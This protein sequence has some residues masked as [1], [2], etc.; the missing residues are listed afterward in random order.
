MKNLSDGS[1]NWDIIEFGGSGIEEVV[2][3]FILGKI[4]KDGTIVEFGAG[5][6]STKV[7]SQYFTLYSVEH[8]PEFVGIYDEVKYVKAPLSEDFY[9][10]PEGKLPF[11]PDLVIIDGK[12]REGIL[13]HLD[14]FHPDTRFLIHDTYRQKEIHLAMNLAQKIGRNAIF[15]DNSDH[16]AFI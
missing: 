16:W 9:D 6:I 8:D 11:T 12:N 3:G 14:W 5:H 13:N 2:F 10:V 4:P 1:I 15:F 7:L